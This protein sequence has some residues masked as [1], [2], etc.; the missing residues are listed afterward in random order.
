MTFHQASVEGWSANGSWGFLSLSFM[1]LF[2]SEMLTQIALLYHI[3]QTFHD[4]LLKSSLITSPK[5]PFWKL[6]VWRV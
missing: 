3:T 2:L 6:M 4:L 5:W 1:H